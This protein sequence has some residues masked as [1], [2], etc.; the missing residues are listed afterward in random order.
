MRQ[1]HFDAEAF[2]RAL[3][4][5]RENKKLSWKKVAEQAGVSASTLTRLAQGKR[6]DVDSL[7]ALTGWAGLKADDFM[8]GARVE[9]VPTSSVDELAALFR[10]DPRLSPEDAAAM[11]TILRTAYE[12]FRKEH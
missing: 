2:Y 12:R 3:D 10:A 1:A 8:Y 5:T 4:N 7:A 9:R 6:P 11:E